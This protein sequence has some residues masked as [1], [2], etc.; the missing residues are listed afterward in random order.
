[1]TLSP[2]TWYTYAYT[3]VETPTRP[4]H[5]NA[6]HDTLGSSQVEGLAAKQ[7][8]QCRHTNT[9]IYDMYHYIVYV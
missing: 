2:Y 7:Y 1:M 8:S 5:G 9:L 3:S 6:P 4:T